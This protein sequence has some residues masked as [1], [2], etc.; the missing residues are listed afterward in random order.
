MELQIQQARLVDA[1]VIADILKEAAAWAE[2]A[3]ER[4]WLESEL[5]A[6]EIAADADAG[7]F[8]LAMHADTP[9]ATVRYQL[10]DALFWPD[11]AE[12]E[13]AYV[14]R[15]A[16]R[17]RWAGRGVAAELLH[18]AARRACLLY[19]SPSPRDATLSRMPSSA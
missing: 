13:A 18:W 7:Q 8:F 11:A 17:R 5:E 9:I 2:R 6:E 10:E 19:T 1:P 4:L 12:G 14:H 3:H 15:L 16:V